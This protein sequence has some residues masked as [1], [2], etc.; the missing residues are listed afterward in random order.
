MDPDRAKGGDPVRATWG[1]DVTPVR[2]GDFRRLPGFYLVFTGEGAAV[3][4]PGDLPGYPQLTGQA[5][6]K[7]FGGNLL[8]LHGM[9]AQVMRANLAGGAS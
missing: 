3:A 7:I 4:G 9:D 5:E 6:R 2:A 1:C 8:R